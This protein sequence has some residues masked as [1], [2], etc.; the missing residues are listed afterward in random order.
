MC[1]GWGSGPREA[2]STDTGYNPFQPEDVPV[3]IRRDSWR[4]HQ[5]RMQEVCSVAC[6]GRVVNPSKKLV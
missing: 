6:P 4:H 2:L 3:S 5:L 1:T